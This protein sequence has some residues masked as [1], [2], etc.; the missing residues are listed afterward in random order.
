MIMRNEMIEIFL[1]MID[2]GMPEYRE[3]SGFSPDGILFAK[4][5]EAPASFAV[6]KKSRRRSK[7]CYYFKKM[8]MLITVAPSALEFVR[9]YGVG[10]QCLNRRQAAMVELTRSRVD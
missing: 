8:V 6:R 10:T 3:T 2:L 7:V 9:S 5:C 1:K 4:P